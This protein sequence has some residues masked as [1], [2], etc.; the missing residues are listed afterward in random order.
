MLEQKIAKIK[1]GEL[2]AVENIK[3]FLGVIKEKNGRVNALLYVNENALKDAAA[4]DKKIKLKKAGKLAGLAI[5]VKA[6]ISVLDF[7]VSCASRTLENY[8]GTFDA[9]V[10]KKIRAEDGII[11]GMA[12]M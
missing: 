7:P 10:I 8:S 5:A 4:V 1:K 9:D 2:S 6:N 11:I 12:N 3:N